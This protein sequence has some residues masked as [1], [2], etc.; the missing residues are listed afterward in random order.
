MKAIGDDGMVIDCGNYKAVDGGVI[1]TE[2]VKRKRVIGFVPNERLRYVLPDEEMDRYERIQGRERTALEEELKE[3]RTRFDRLA[4]TVER[5]RKERSGRLERSADRIEG[6]EHTDEEDERTESRDRLD[7][8]EET[9]DRRARET[10]ADDRSTGTT[11]DDGTTGEGER[12]G[13]SGFDPVAIVAEQTETEDTT[14]SA[15]NAERAEDDTDVGAIDVGGP[16]PVAVVA[17]QNAETKAEDETKEE[18]DERAPD[19]ES[20]S[21]AGT[22]ADGETELQRIDGLGRT[23]ATRLREAEIESLDDL[24]EA[25]VEAITTATGIGEARAENWIEQA[26][27]L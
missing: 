3:L 21:N 23:Y 20:E 17:A 13:T 19:G 11:V 5:D 6:T 8:I 2:D 27:Q 4:T 26:E 12:I 22:E 7:R 18:S 14:R 24:R 10:E 9:G 1:L 16:D 25:D 15:E